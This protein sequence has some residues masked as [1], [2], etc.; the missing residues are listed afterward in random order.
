MKASPLL[1]L[2]THLLYLLL[3]QPYP[4]IVEKVGW[5]STGRNPG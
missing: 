5:A 2:L 3:L 1:S 4:V